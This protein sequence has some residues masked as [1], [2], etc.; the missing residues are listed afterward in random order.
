[1]GHPDKVD[2]RWR[3]WLWWCG[4]P[5]GSFWCSWAPWGR[6]LVFLG[7]WGLGSQFGRVGGPPPTGIG[8]RITTGKINS[9]GGPRYPAALGPRVFQRVSDPIG[10]WLASSCTF[11]GPRSAG[12][13]AAHYREHSVHLWTFYGTGL[14]LLCL[15]K[16]EWVGLTICA[17]THNSCLY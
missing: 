3:W 17:V 4:G 1:M 15:K 16:T 7:F 12:E 11:M 8:R 9:G 2:A 5:G 6:L 14:V 10:V 13:G